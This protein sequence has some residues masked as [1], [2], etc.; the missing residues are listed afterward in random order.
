MKCMCIKIAARN[1]DRGRDSSGILPLGRTLFVGI[2]LD[3][4]GGGRGLN[5][6]DWIHEPFDSR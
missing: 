5:I 6:G 2:G 1:S 3:D 4:G